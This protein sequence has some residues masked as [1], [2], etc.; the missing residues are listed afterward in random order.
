[1]RRVC[2]QSALVAFV[3]AWA[4]AAFATPP[5][6]VPFIAHGDQ[7]MNVWV[8]GDQQ[9]LLTYSQDSLLKI[10]HIKSRRLLQTFDLKL[11][12][13]QGFAIAPGGRL[14]VGKRPDGSR[15]AGCYRLRA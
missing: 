15:K 6:I 2:R 12:N 1:M 10:W 7:I 8:S 4:T 13:I 3:I 5:R 14:L 9:L 11:I